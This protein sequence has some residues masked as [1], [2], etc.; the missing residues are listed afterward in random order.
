M[1]IPA[2]VKADRKSPRANAEDA[3]L[4]APVAMHPTDRAVHCEVDRLAG[5]DVADPVEDV[6]DAKLEEYAEM[7]DMARADV[8]EGTASEVANCVPLDEHTAV[9]VEAHDAYEEVAEDARG[10]DRVEGDSPEVGMPV[11]EHALARE[12]ILVEEDNA[13]GARVDR[14]QVPVDDAIEGDEESVDGHCS[15]PSYDAMAEAQVE[16][17]VGCGLGACAAPNEATAVIDHLGE[18]SQADLLVTE[19]GMGELHVM[20]VDDRNEAIVRMENRRDESEA[21]AARR[22]VA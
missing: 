22:A 5:Q 9:L 14:T 13:S 21:F 19:R 17:A 8:E 12:A 18:H 2:A 4:S 10:Y 6:L 20:T 16:S 11:L 1:H 3:S 15:Y 7:M